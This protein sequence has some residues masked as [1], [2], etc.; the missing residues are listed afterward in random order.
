MFSYLRVF[1]YDVIPL[2]TVIEVVYTG[3]LTGSN[4][5]SFCSLNDHLIVKKSLSVQKTI[6]CIAL[7]EF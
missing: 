6:M 1:P 3:Y 5:L 7:S 4:I 2:Q